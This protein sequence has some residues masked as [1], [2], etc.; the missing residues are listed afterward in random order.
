[1]SIAADGAECPRPFAGNLRDCGRLDACCTAPSILGPSYATV[2][3][4]ADLPESL[5][6]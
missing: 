2:S 1:M 5:A 3:M 4:R 6:T